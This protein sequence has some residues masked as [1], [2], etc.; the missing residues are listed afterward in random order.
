MPELP[1]K[2]HGI[3]WPLGKAHEAGQIVR[4]RCGGCRRKRYYLPEDLQRLFGD[5][6]VN[7]L[8]RRMRCESC[9]AKEISVEVFIPVASE[10]ARMTIRRLV[11]IRVRRVPVWRDKHGNRDG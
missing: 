5:V 11:E 3:I 1:P 2:P 4:V 10:R 7:V 9:N 6:D 8:H